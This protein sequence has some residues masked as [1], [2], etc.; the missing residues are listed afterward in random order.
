MIFVIASVELKQGKRDDFLDEF[1]KIV[2]LVREERGCLEYGPTVDVATNIAA[3]GEVRENVVTVVEKWQSIEDLEAH[4][5]A[6]HMMEYRGKVKDM[7][8]GT[9]LQIL[10]PA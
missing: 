5:I 1:R 2:P 9:R 4:L 7:V 8:A 10:E 6:P 3:Q